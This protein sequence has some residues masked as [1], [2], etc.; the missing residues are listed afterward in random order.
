MA[1]HRDTIRSISA[2]SGPSIAKPAS[3]PICIEQAKVD[4]AETVASVLQEAA[5]WLANTGR[6]LWI[7]SEVSYERVLRDTQAGSF[8]AARDGDDVIGVMRFELEDPFFWPEVEAGTSAFVHKLAVRRSWA[9]RGVSTALLTFARERARSL[10]RQH[11]RLD[12]LADRPELRAIYERFGFALH[13]SVQKGALSYARYEL[14]V[15]D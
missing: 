1:N 9:K 2:T 10:R 3:S 4:D 14:T 7:P 13:S 6:P 5:Q 11:L 12:C 15:T 8:F